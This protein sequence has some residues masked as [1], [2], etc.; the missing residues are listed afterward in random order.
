M[1][2]EFGFRVSG[3]GFRLWVWGTIPLGGGGGG[4]RYGD[5]A[6]YILCF[7]VRGHYA[8]YL[9]G[10]GTRQG[11]VTK[12]NDRDPLRLHLQRLRSGGSCHPRPQKSGPEKASRT[13]VSIIYKTKPCQRWAQDSWKEIV[14]VAAIRA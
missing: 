9:G 7:R 3:L 10:P 5:T 11:S 2:L 6:P 13:A 8:G 12:K 4:Y 1:G 14:H